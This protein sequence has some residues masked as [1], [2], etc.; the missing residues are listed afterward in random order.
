M[1]F[2]LIKLLIARLLIVSSFCLFLC[3]CGNKRALFLE[4][5]ETQK[6]SKTQT[7]KSEVST[8]VDSKEEQISNGNPKP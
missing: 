4:S 8:N 1:N 2:F 7:V 3:N 6:N 5:P